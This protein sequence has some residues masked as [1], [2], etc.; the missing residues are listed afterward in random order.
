MPSARMSRVLTKRFRDDPVW[1]PETACRANC[2]CAKEKEAMAHDERSLV[3]S[4]EQRTAALE[5]V[6]RHKGEMPET[7]VHD[8][9][10][11]AKEKCITDNAARMVARAWIDPSFRT[12]LLAD[13]PAAANEMGFEFPEHHRQLVVLE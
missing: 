13:G 12:R 2:S 7:F 6:L 5:I 11:H 1:R 4:P 10:E 8:F 3:A 9:T